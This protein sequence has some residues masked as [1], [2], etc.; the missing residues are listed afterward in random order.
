VRHVPHLPYTNTYTHTQTHTHTHTHT[1]TLSLSRS[2]SHTRSL[3]A[4][5]GFLA[6]VGVVR[7][8][9]EG[10][11]VV[12]HHDARVRHVP[13]LFWIWDLGFIVSGCGF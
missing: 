1:H 10:P 12:R 2:L 13:H 7:P 5:A 8:V 9:R 11:A 6:V 4:L 3:F